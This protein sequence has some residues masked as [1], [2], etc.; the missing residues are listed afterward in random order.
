MKRSRC[1]KSLENHKIRKICRVDLTNCLKIKPCSIILTDCNRNK[2]KWYRIKIG[3]ILPEVRLPKVTLRKINDKPY[4]GSRSQTLD[5]KPKLE[6]EP[7]PLAGFDGDPYLNAEYFRILLT[8]TSR[9]IKK[10]LIRKNEPW[11][12]EG[13]IGN[14]DLNSEYFRLLLQ[15]PT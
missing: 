4:L 12:L 6:I 5:R 15:S 9:E 10:K 1:V 2:I 8:P 3:G 13:F 11:V 14:P 7:W